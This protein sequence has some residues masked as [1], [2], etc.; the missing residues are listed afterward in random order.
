MWENANQILISPY[1]LIH[2]LTSRNNVQRVAK[3]NS[4]N[5]SYYCIIIS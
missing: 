1:L 2:N 5:Y 3:N 4:V